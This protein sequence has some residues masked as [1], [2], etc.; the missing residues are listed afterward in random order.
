MSLSMAE[1]ETI[2]TFNATQEDA[3]VFTS[4]PK[5][6]RRLDKIEGFKLV[7]TERLDGKVCAKEFECPRLFAR[8]TNS[9]IAVGK[10]RKVSEKQRQHMRR[11]RKS[12]LSSKSSI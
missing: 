3:S 5:V 7:R 6:W 11:V 1:R 12:F 8:L 10:P 4:Q 9:G 2:T